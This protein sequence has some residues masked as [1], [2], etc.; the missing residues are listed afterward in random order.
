MSK[1]SRL[2]RVLLAPI[3]AL[4]RVRD[5]YVRSIT[6]CAGHMNYGSGFGYD[7]YN[8]PRSFSVTS[9]H[10][11]ASDEDLRELIRAV[12]QKQIK[13]GGVNGMPPR[14]RSVAVGRIDEDAPFDFNGADN[15]DVGSNLLFPRSQSYAPGSIKAQRFAR[16]VV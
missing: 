4:G 5:F 8:L 15:L 16:A 3:R 13:S 14:S 10:V 11:S 7:G 12:S 1:P 2:S 9:D 6:G